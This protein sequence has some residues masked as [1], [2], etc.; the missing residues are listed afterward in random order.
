MANSQS[1]APASGLLL[2]GLVLL[3][4]VATARAEVCASDDHGRKLCLEQPAER[5]IALS[6]GLTELL[7]D[8]GAGDR[9]VGTTSHTDYPP[10]ARDIP[11]VG[12]YKRFDLEAALGL[13]P[14]LLVAWIS[15]N[16]GS[17]VERIEAM[18]VPVF[19][20]EQRR[21]EDVAAS[22]ER[23][24]RLAGTP[25]VADR[26][27]RGFRQ[28]I[29]RIRR[30]F[31]DAATVRVFYQVWEEPLMTVNGDHLISQAMSLCGAENIFSGLPRLAPRVDIETVLAKNPEA[32]LVGG[33]GEKNKD[34]LEPWREFGHL[35]AAGRNNLFFVPP[36][37]LQRPTPRIVAGIETV[38][39][40]M[41]TVRA[42]R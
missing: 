2:A 17:Q 39:E 20:L 26:V 9:V 28:D 14:D 38:C 6:P 27:A 29:E 21:I 18:G 25:R 1:I 40:H 7:F 10:A 41:E 5:I 11:R 12:S 22:L 37:T 35:D 13:E 31:D 15:G 3:A 33:L 34:W 4:G 42:R 32:I 36:S 24:G 16:P 8:A 23:L 19:W 30:R